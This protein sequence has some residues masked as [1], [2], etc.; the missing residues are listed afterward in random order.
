MSD[1][2]E[3]EVTRLLGVD[4]MRDEGT[5]VGNDIVDGRERI[6]V[7]GVA[8]KEKLA[9]TATSI[10]GRSTE[11]HNAG[12]GLVELIPQISLLIFLL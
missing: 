10:S 7:L 2:H 6:D 3:T 1:W 8:L 12:V 5:N 11:D 9:V 4:R